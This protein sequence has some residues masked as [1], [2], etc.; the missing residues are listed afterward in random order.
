MAT[1]GAYRSLYLLNWVYRYFTEPYY[2]YAHLAH[3]LTAGGASSHP[4]SFG[5]LCRPSLS[6]VSPPPYFLHLCPVFDTPP[7]PSSAWIAWIAGIVQ[8]AF[9]C[10]FM[11]YYVISKYRGMQHTPL[12]Q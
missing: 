1:L 5:A 2:R 4:A 7:P 3:L 6:S 9:Y 10:D 11:Y 8:T 12:P